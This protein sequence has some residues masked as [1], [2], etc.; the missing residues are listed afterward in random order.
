M[1]DLTSFG[2]AL[3]VVGLREELRAWEAGGRDEWALGDLPP[4]VW[5]IAFGAHGVSQ[6]P[7][8]CLLAHGLPADVVSR[9]KAR[10]HEAASAAREAIVLGSRWK[11]VGRRQPLGGNELLND[12]LATALRAKLEFTREELER[13]G[14]QD[15]QIGSFI[16]VGDEYYRQ[17]ASESVRFFVSAPSTSPSLALLLLSPLLFEVSLGRPRSKA[18]PMTSPPLPLAILSGEHLASDGA[19][20]GAARGDR[21]GRDGRGRLAGAPAG[22]QARGV[23]RAASHES[24][25]LERASAR[26]PWIAAECVC[27]P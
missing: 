27:L 23:R 13:F 20:Q 1:P 4:L 10:L 5:D 2:P 18:L 9:L 15:L 17:A 12:A 14:L 8:V 25:V 24:L 7:S 11:A 19:C 21:R 3:E 26:V 22:Q 16:L 6:Q